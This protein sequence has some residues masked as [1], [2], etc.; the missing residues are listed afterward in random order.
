MV[1]MAVPG[2]AQA[3]LTWGEPQPVLTPRGTNVSHVR[4]AVG[5]AGHA[6]AVWEADDGTAKVIQGSL[7]EPGQ[8]MQLPAKLTPATNFGG[9][10]A[11]E[12]AIDGAGNAAATWDASSTIAS[13]VIAVRRPAGGVFAPQNAQSILNGSNQSNGFTLPK[14]VFEPSGQPRVVWTGASPNTTTYTAV[15]TNLGLANST[16]TTAEPATPQSPAGSDQPDEQQLAVAPDGSALLVYRWQPGAKNQIWASFK[17]AGSS[18]FGDRKVV[19][20]SDDGF[21]PQVAYAGNGEFAIAFH[22]PGSSIKASTRAVDGTYSIGTVIANTVSVTDGPQ[23]QGTEVKLRSNAAGLVAATYIDASNQPRVALK[24]VGQ[25]WSFPAFITNGGQIGTN[26]TQSLWPDVAVDDAGDVVAI[27]R[28]ND[29]TLGTIR[30]AYKPAGGDWPR[31]AGAT[32]QQISP[33]GLDADHPVVG[34]DAKGNAVAAWELLSEG[35]Y[36]MQVVQ[37]SQPTPPGEEPPASPSEP[38][39]A[40]PEPP[41]PPPAPPGLPVVTDLKLEAPIRRGAPIVVTAVTSGAVQKLQWTIAGGQTIAGETVN[42][43]LQRTVRFRASAAKF[44]VAVRAVGPGGTGPTL[45][46]AFAQAAPR[47]TRAASP[48]DP[49]GKALEQVKS[50]DLKAMQ[51]KVEREGPTMAVGQANALLGLSGDCSIPT[52]VQTGAQSVTGCLKAVP[53]LD[54]LP[55]AERGILQP[56]AQELGISTSDTDKLRAAVA[57]SDGFVTT[58][59]LQLPGGFPLEPIGGASILTLPQAKAIASANAGFRIGGDLIKRSGFVLPMDPRSAALELGRIA[60]P[61]KLPK[62]GGFDLAP[63]VDISFKD[64]VATIKATL[65]LPSILKTGGVNVQAGVTLRATPTEFLIDNV[66]IGPI[67]VAIGGIGVSGLKLSYTRATDTWQG[68]GKACLPGGACLDMTPPH[69]LVR[70]VGGRLDFAGATLVF[71]LPG[72]VLFP[73]LTMENIGFGIGTDPTRIT[74]KTRIAI[75]NLIAYDGTM[76]TAFPSAATPYYL[77]RQEVG[78]GFAPGLY[79]VPHTRPTVAISAEPLVELPGIGETKLG[80]GYLLY[81]FP[82]YSAFGGSVDLSL[83][84]IIGLKGGVSGELEAT[85]GV[86]NLHGDIEGCVNLV[87]SV[88]ATAVANISR[89]K[90]NSGGAG[91]CVGVGGIHIGGGVQWNRLSDPFIWPFDGCKWSPFKIDVRAQTAQAGRPT[92]LTAGQAVRLDGQGG[93]PLVKV[94]AP[95]GEV[96]Q[97]APGSGLTTGAGGKVRI[98]RFEGQ[99]GTFTV[100]GIQEPA[101]GSWSVS[102]VDGSAPVVKTSRATDP[103]DAKVSARVTGTG[104][105]RTLT[106]DIA[107]REG[108]A[109]TFQEIGGGAAKVIGRVTGGGKGTLRFRPAPGRGQRSVQAQFELAGIPAERQT[110]ARFTAPSP[111]LAAPRRLHATR[112]RRGLTVTWAGVTGAQGYEVVAT[113]RGGG[114]RLVRTRGRRAVVP[115]AQGDAG[116]VTVRATAMSREG[117]R[118]AARAFKAMTTKRTGLRTLPRCAGKRKVVCKTT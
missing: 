69:G 33:A 79:G 64:G 41:P 15:F 109:V 25:P 68:E 74:A 29:G 88:C 78:D 100:V 36:R 91:G 13:Q 70:F 40:T 71:P 43:Q 27:W 19:T 114:Q 89:G 72:V 67:D 118:A 82:G 55:S 106:Y 7:R 56:L 75:A 77:N 117:R 20:N 73:G 17:P 110:V 12:V 102:T 101:N 50:A 5:A 46:R 65:K 62:I 35:N 10:E 1:V 51:D 81:E 34:L 97:S 4:L 3:Q 113:V 85:Q 61:P 37:G 66:T 48:T 108:Q 28:S 39:P 47:A 14:I 76:V 103:P 116:N 63:D 18:V 32:G 52:T 42:G 57:L 45:G 60:R 2:T 11:P 87:V 96:V 98:L 23:P 38:P 90:G 95:G 86:F 104:D 83:V 115:L 93:A 53:G 21:R 26:G 58:Q 99:A 112:T 44:N 30:T 22:T 105:V 24:P 8:F 84:G 92:V 6:A 16:W 107:P 94:T 31:V 49:I 80:R 9:A 111:F 54:D 59:P